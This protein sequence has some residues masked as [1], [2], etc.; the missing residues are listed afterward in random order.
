MYKRQETRADNDTV[1]G[2]LARIHHAQTALC[3][4]A[5]RGLLEGLDGSC[6]TPI[7]AFARLDGEQLHLKAE[8]LSLK[9]DERYAADIVESISTP[10]TARDLGLRLAKTIR[11][12]VG[13]FDRLFADELS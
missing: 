8:V 4:S 13:D 6:R 2:V 10:E 9:G 1:R 5:E 11:A 12:N 7:A 3:I